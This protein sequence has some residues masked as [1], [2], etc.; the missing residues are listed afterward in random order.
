MSETVSVE[1]FADAAAEYGVTVTRV[2]PEESVREAVAEAVEQPAVGVPLPSGATLP[3]SVTAQPTPAELDAAVTGVTPAA[4]AVAD[5]GSLVLRADGSGTEPV[6][7][8]VDR[9]VAVLPRDR[10]RPDMPAA[11]DWFG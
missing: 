10:I 9:H 8:F 6:S 11:F 5:Y 4:G 7:L 1:R 3:D 2:A